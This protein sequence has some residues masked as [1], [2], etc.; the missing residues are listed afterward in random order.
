MDIKDSLHVNAGEGG[1]GKKNKKTTTIKKPLQQL[2]DED[3]GKASSS[4]GC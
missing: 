2:R 1:E 3:A 4:R